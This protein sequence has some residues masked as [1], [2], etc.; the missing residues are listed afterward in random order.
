MKAQRLSR[1][2]SQGTCKA[3]YG[4]FRLNNIGH[5]SSRRYY[6]GGWHRSCPALANHRF[7][8]GGTGTQGGCHSMSPYRSC[9]H[10]RVFAPAAPRRAWI[11]VSESISGLLLPQPVR[12]TGTPVRYT[13]VNLIRRRPI[14]GRHLSTTKHSSISDPSG[15]IPSF[16]GL[17]RTLGQVIHVLLSSLPRSYTS[18]LAWLNRTP[19]AVTSGRINQK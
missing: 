4:P 14:Q 12:I 2:I 13:G 6:R 18:R 1:W 11:R 8:D 7:L 15:I 3:G 16:P 10:C 19:I 5:H 9:L 17:S